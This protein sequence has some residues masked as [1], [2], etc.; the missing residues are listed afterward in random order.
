MAWSALALHG[1]L[2]SVAFDDHFKDGGV[3]HQPVYGGQRHGLIRKDAPAFMSCATGDG[4][5]ISVA[6]MII[7]VSILMPLDFR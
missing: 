1:C 4:A 5:E 7:P 3:V 2:A 6:S